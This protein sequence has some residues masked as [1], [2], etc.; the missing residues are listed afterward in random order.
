MKRTTRQ[1]ERANNKKK[2]RTD[3][4]SEARNCDDARGHF[5]VGEYFKVD[6]NALHTKTVQMNYERVGDGTMYVFWLDGGDGTSICL[7]P[8]EKLIE[9]PDCNLR[10]N[11][12]CEVTGMQRRA[13]RAVDGPMTKRRLNGESSIWQQLFMVKQVELISEEF[14]KLFM[15]ELKEVIKADCLVNVDS[16]TMRVVLEDDVRVCDKTKRRE[17]KD[18]LKPL[19]H[20]MTDANVLAVTHRYFFEDC[21]RSD[22]KDSK[23]VC[24][25]TENERKTFLKRSEGLGGHFFSVDEETG[26]FSKAAVISGF[27]DSL[28]RMT[29]GD[30]NNM[31]ALRPRRDCC[32]AM[33][34]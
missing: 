2:K 23:G 1:S 4:E 5:H 15:S 22:R 18:V 24:F 6:E 32:H 9:S 20:V 27:P 31:H 25:L 11:S 30:R 28:E 17:G 13:C 16:D 26:L 12:R 19:D 8:V 7:R 21:M 10:E 14:E 33:V 3:G 29:D 34:P